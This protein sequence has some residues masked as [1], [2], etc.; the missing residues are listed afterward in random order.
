MKKLIIFLIFHLNFFLKFLNLKSH[1]F[2]LVCNIILFRSL[3]L[4]NN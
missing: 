1:L 3:S 4:A 2:H